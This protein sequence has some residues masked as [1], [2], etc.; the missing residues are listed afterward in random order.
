[1]NVAGS[2]KIAGID[3]AGSYILGVIYDDDSLSL[4]M[5]FRLEESHPK[6]TPAGDADGCFHKGYV[7]FAA[8]EELRLRKSQAAPDDNL[9]LSVIYAAE[10]SDDHVVID[11]AWGEIE[12]AAATIQVVVD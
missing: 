4:D 2:G 3:L 10:F 12:V 1:M 5:D 6:Y 11:S 7:R 8:I 9:N